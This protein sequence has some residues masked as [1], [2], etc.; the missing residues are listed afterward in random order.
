MKPV[1]DLFRLRRALSSGL[2][3]ETAAILAYDFH[4]RMTPQPVGARDNITIFENIDDGATLEVDDDRPVGLRLSPTPII[5]P[6]D[7]RAWWRNLPLGLAEFYFFLRPA[8]TS[9]SPLNDISQL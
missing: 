6:D 5:D 2:G 7:P 3:V 4:L 1:G 9:A 8:E